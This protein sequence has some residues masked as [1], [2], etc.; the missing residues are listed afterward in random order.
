MPREDNFFFLF[1]P[2]ANDEVPRC[3]IKPDQTLRALSIRKLLGTVSIRKHVCKSPWLPCCAS[4]CRDWKTRRCMPSGIMKCHITGRKR[5]GANR[6][7]HRVLR[8]HRHPW[9]PRTIYF[10]VPP[11]H[12]W[13]INMEYSGTT[14]FP[15]ALKLLRLSGGLPRTMLDMEWKIIH[16]FRSTKG[17]VDYCLRLS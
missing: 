5:T 4:V 1:S 7:M 9:V 2:V 10:S 17:L 3:V 16:L 13:E 14:W 12:P 8:V 6:S 15:F 11:E